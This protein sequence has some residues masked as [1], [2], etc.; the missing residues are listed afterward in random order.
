MRDGGVVIAAAGLAPFGGLWRAYPDRAEFRARADEY[1][2]DGVALA[3][4]VA[5]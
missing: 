1:L 4:A 5:R 3:D 2:A